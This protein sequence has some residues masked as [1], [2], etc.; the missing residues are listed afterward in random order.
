MTRCDLLKTYEDKI[1]RCD[2]LKKYEDEIEKKI[3]MK[4]TEEIHFNPTSCL[5]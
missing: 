1:T 2:P 5:S 3:K 4:L